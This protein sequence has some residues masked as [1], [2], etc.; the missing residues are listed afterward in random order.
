M[1]TSNTMHYSSLEMTIISAENLYISKKQRVKELS[2]VIRGGSGDECTTKMPTE[3]GDGALTWN[4][5]VDIKLP[6]N[7]GFVFMEV[8]CRYSSGKGKLVGAS[9]VSVKDI[10][11]GFVPTN[12]LQFLSYR[13]R[14]SD[15]DRNG[16]I[17]ISVRVKGLPRR[18]SATPVQQ[19]EV[20]VPMGGAQRFGAVVTGVPAA[21]YSHPQL[22]T[23]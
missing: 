8:Y 2:V 20:G 7:A 18:C 6:E 12:H 16:I 11:G 14:D 5:K 1:D 3:S 23:K 4:E 21:W 22:W 17:N 9:R 19:P 15:G 13:L 10:L